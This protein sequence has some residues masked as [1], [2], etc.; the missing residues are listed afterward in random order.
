VKIA[1]ESTPDLTNVGEARVRA[2]NGTTERGTPCT[3][4]VLAITVRDAV[5][6]GAEFEKEVREM[7]PEAKYMP[8]SMLV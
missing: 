5:K 7:L 3:V 4:F 8:L 2:W 1:I 6:D